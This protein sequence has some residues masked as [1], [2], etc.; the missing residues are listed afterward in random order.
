MAKSIT[1]SSSDSDLDYVDVNDNE[2]VE[3]VPPKRAGKGRGPD[4][5]WIEIA[6]FSNVDSYKESE[7]YDDIKEYFTMR[8]GRE[9]YFADTLYTCKFARKRGYVKCPL[10][11]KLAFM[12][13]SEEVI[14]MTNGK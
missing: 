11:Y 5:E 9:S 7:Y 6:R 1:M 4:I 14:A 8:K 3:N 13:T 10:E 12:T 2:E